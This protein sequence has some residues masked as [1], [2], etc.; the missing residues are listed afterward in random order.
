MHQRQFILLTD[1]ASVFILRLAAFLPTSLRIIVGLAWLMVK[2]IAA[3][4]SVYIRGRIL[5]TF[6]TTIMHQHHISVRKPHLL[7]QVICPL[8]KKPHNL[9]VIYQIQH[10]WNS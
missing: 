2:F 8:L 5:S 3:I 7:N 9:C 10:F 4:C 6:D 1:F